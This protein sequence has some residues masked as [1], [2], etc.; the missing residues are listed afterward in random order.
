MSSISARA[1]LSQLEGPCEKWYQQHPLPPKFVAPTPPYRNP[2][3]SSHPKRESPGSSCVDK[4]APQCQ[5]DSEPSQQGTSL[6]Y[7]HS[8]TGSKTVFSHEVPK[9]LTQLSQAARQTQTAV[10]GYSASNTY[11]SAQRSG[12]TPGDMNDFF[13]FEGFEVSGAEE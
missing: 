8:S 6:G 2:S 1:K 4:N 5:S 7:K 11:D 10:S 12:D 13:D 3:V 9:A